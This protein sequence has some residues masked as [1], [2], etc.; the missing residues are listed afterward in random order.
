MAIHYRTEAVILKKR[1]V[2]EADRVFTVFTRDLGKVSLVAVGERK[3]TSK[4]RGGLEALCLSEIE[5]VEGRRSTVIDAS[6]IEGYRFLKTDLRRTRAALRVTATLDVFLKGQAQDEKAWKLLIETLD[7]LND[8]KVSPAKW[9]PL[10]YYFFW[11]LVSFL[12]WRPNMSNISPPASSF[13][14]DAFTSSLES[15]VKA[16]AGD[17]QAESALASLSRAHFLAI[18]K[19]IQ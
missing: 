18:T 11:N 1:E 5:F 6:P 14:S 9:S 10:Y 16:H 17:F 2:G 8:P 15:F 3:I 13:L 4:L 7:T 19:G 12:G